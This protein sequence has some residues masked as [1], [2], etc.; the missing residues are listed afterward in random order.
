MRTTWTTGLVATSGIIATGTAISIAS[1]T[2]TCGTVAA[3]RTIATVTALRA[4]TA[5]TSIAT[6][7]LSELLCHRFKRLVVSDERD[8][9]NF[10]N[11][12]AALGDADD[13]DAI[14]VEFCFGF[15]NISGL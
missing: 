11:F 9:F 12:D 4:I 5:V 10:V 7:F 3:C 14:N 15:D 6:I 2:I 1:S 8:F 13:R